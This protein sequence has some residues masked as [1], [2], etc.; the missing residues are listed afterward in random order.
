MIE[1]VMTRAEYETE[2]ERVTVA[3]AVCRLGHYPSPAQVAEERQ[4][5]G[6]EVL[7]NNPLPKVAVA[8]ATA[9]LKA[10]GLVIPTLKKGSD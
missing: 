4:I 6:T 2:V 1:K 9:F 7:R 5:M 8:D 3:R 10:R